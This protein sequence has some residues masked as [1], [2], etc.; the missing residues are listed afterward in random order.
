M[1]RAAHSMRSRSVHA[2]LLCAVLTCLP[3]FSLAQDQTLPAGLLSGNQGLATFL[4]FASTEDQVWQWHYAAGEFG[5]NAPIVITQLSVRTFGHAPSGA[6]DFASLEVVMSSSPTSYSLVGSGGNPGHDPVFANN[7]SADQVVV[8]PAAPFVGNANAGRWIRLGL[9]TPFVFDPTADHD[10]VV[11]LRVCGVNTAMTAPLLAQRGAPGQNGG[12]RYGTMGSCMATSSSFANDELVPVLL[13]ESHPQGAPVLWQVNQ[14]AAS[15]TVD[16]QPGTPYRPA[17]FQRCINEFAVAAFESTNLGLPWDAAVVVQKPVPV[18]GGG[19]ALPDG[20]IVNVNLLDPQL[21]YQ[22][23]GVAPSFTASTF[24]AN[25]ILPFPIANLEISRGMQIIVADP[26]AP[27]GFALSGA[28]HIEIGAPT[29]ASGPTADEELIVVR[30]GLSPICG[31]RLVSFYGTTYPA[32]Y[33]SSNGRVRTSG[34]ATDFSPTISEALSGSPFVGFWAD[35]DPSLGGSIEIQGSGTD[36]LRV[37]WRDVPFYGEPTSAVNFWVEFDETNG[38]VTLGGLSGIPAQPMP[39]G[40]AQYLGLSAGSGVAQAASPTL[41]SPG[42]GFSPSDPFGLVFDFWDGLGTGPGG[43]AEARLLSL[44]SGV[45]AITFTFDPM[46]GGVST[47]SA[48]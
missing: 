11:Q 32:L 5:A 37:T 29:F 30:P 46:G 36:L 47:W 16:D 40:S 18:G 17:F 9:T 4:P 21:T 35:L 41:F 38:T 33:V 42:A 10:L 43:T 39:V 7:L 25:L 44:Q 34:G 26:G 23:G 12:N 24:L 2:V 48:P 6:F 20:Q 22:Y 13:V 31:P 45:D 28:S 19:F 15:L 27:L 8:R 3:S 14:P 1:S